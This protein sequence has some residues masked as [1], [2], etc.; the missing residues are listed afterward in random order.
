MKTILRHLLSIFLPA[1]LLCQ[2]PGCAWGE[3]VR[4]PVWAGRFYPSDARTLRA[5]I[6]RLVT[7][8]GPARADLPD[9]VRLRALILPHA[10]VVYSGWT[11]AHGG[12][13]LGKGRF[14]KVILVGP[15]HR[16]G[17]AGGA[18]SDATGYETPLGCTPL[19]PDA[20]DLLGSDL[21][22]AVAASDRQEH[23][24]EVV[25]PFLQHFMGD[26]ALVPV[27]MGPADPAD[28][29]RSLEAILDDRTLMV[30][31]SD[32]SH[33]LPYDAAVA[34]DRMTIEAIV[35]LDG[36][37]LAAMENAACGKLPILVLVELARRRGW[38]PV[39]LHASNS[40]DTAGERSRVVGYAAIAFYEKPNVQGKT[41]MTELSEPQGRLLV[42]LAR[43][44][45]GQTLG[46]ASPG[47]LAKMLDAP[48]FQARQGTF[49]TLTIDGRLRGC[50]G[51]IVPAG[52]V[53]EGVQRNA[54]HAAF[55]DPRFSPLT[56]E[57]LDTVEI[58]VSLLTPAK[59]LF[60]AG[61]EDLVGRLRPN[62]DGV[63]IR[64]GTRSA[65][66]LPQVWDQLPDPESFLSHLCQKAGLGV[67][68]WRSGLLDVETYQVRHFEERD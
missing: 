42:Q 41:P 17:F 66:F 29:A 3:N 9:S 18:I 22:R 64:Q 52:S 34:K 39:V 56:A 37:R 57:E 36:P 63:I 6:D 55:D 45:I 60:Y 43:A 44:A 35:D 26:F 51:N 38:K 4:K 13:V 46:Q 65:T 47:P 59:P 15:D 24:L 2:A 53:V 33:F 30:V 54:V 27:V 32:L 68:A 31:S 40:G 21:F 14:D 10:G 48:A 7:E 49:V 16:V 28:Y 11:A 19:H 1:L 50:I 61:P 20:G 5:D 62:V 67:D 25:L 8:C 58:E 12:W 23:S